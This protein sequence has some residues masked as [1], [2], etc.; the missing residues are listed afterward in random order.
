MALYKDGDRLKHSADAAFD[1]IHKPGETVPHSGIYRCTSC[2]DEIACNKGDP[3]PPQNHH[4]HQPPA[5]I[6]W[7]LLVYAV[8]K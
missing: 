3:F 5:P 6:R 7:R 1:A 4:Q 2:D 8:Q